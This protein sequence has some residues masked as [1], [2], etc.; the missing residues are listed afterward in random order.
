MAGEAFRA[1]NLGGGPKFSAAGGSCVEYWIIKEIPPNDIDA[2]Q[3]NLGLPKVGDNH[4]DPVLSGRVG[5]V[6]SV[7]RVA[8]YG[9]LQWVAMVR[10]SQ[11]GTFNFSTNI[12]SRLSNLSPERTE[13]PVQQQVAGTGRYVSL[14]PGFFWRYRFR[15]TESRQVSAATYS[16]GL[17]QNLIATN[18]GRVYTF[19]S[20][21]YQL[22]GCT[23]VVDQGNNVRVDT[24]FDTTARVAAIGTNIYS[25]EQDVP[26]PLLEPLWDYAPGNGAVGVSNPVDRFGLGAVLPWI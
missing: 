18:I 23:A 19:N 16:L 17:I 3:V 24:D 4:Y 20:L 11:G 14:E 21:Q 12:G 9:P 7:E 1:T 22:A 2:A 8:E 6:Q 15:R 10:W 25:P 26:L 5:T 13:I